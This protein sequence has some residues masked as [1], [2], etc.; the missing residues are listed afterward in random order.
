MPKTAEDAKLQVEQGFVFWDFEK[1]TD[2]GDQKKFTYSG[3]LK[4]FSLKKGQAPVVRPDG[5]RSGLVITPA[6]AGGNNNVDV[7]AGAAFV[8]GKDLAISA[9]TNLA[10][11]RTAAGGTFQI[12][13]VVIDNAGVI[14]AVGGTEG[15]AFSLTRGAAGGPPYVP[16]DKIEIGQ[17]KLTSNTDAPILASE[18]DQ[19]V[20]ERYDIPSFVTVPEEAAIR[21]LTALDKRHTADV[22]KGIWVK[23]Y[24]PVFNDIPEASNWKP[25]GVKADSKSGRTYDGVF[26]I[27]SKGLGE[28]SFDVLLKGENGEILS[29]V[30][31]DTRWFRFY[32]DKFRTDHHLVC[33]DLTYDR[34]YP[35]DNVM[36]A[37][38][39]VNGVVAAIEK[40]S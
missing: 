21:M 12:T 23:H 22:T 40:A 32:P 7:A 11:T 16:V 28:G 9:A 20:M 35:P 34:E 27:G 26:S 1:G 4:L 6:L 3:T 39:K 14:S 18:I 10:M 17:V 33:G 15:S 19:N 29:S 37:S 36:K 8:G 30:V 5:A 24:E 13:S 31:N 38:C 2:S 25:V